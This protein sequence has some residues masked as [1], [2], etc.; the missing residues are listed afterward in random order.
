MQLQREQMCA[1]HGHPAQGSVNTCCFTRSYETQPQPLVGGREEMKGRKWTWTLASKIHT[2]VSQLD[3]IF[4]R[5]Y[6]HIVRLCTVS[7]RH[8]KV[9]IK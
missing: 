4:E 5:K 3:L 7:T 6:L 2:Y 1:L 8:S 9:V